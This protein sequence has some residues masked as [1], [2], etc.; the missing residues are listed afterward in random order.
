MKTIYGRDHEKAV[1]D[2]HAEWLC[3]AVDDEGVKTLVLHGPPGIGKTALLSEL[4]ARVVSHAGQTPH[5]H[6]LPYDSSL[7]DLGKTEFLSAALNP[8]WK[9]GNK[10]ANFFWFGA[11]FD[12]PSYRQYRPFSFYDSLASLKGAWLERLDKSQEAAKSTSLTILK[13]ALRLIPAFTV[14][15]SLKTATE[16]GLDLVENGLDGADIL[17]SVRKRERHKIEQVEGAILS[18]SLELPLVLVLD[19]AHWAFAP[20]AGHDGL[21]IESLLNKIL[22]KDMTFIERAIRVL[23]A[24]MKRLLDRSALRRKRVLLVMTV[25]SAAY[26]QTLLAGA[27]PASKGPE[28]P[29]TLGAVLDELGR[30]ITPLAL[31]RLGE[32]D[33]RRVFE[34]AYR[35][36]LQDPS[37]RRPDPVD[38]LHTAAVVRAA[39]LDSGGLPLRIRE[40]AVLH[41]AGIA[42]DGPLESAVIHTKRLRAI[43]D[44]ERGLTDILRFAAILAASSNRVARPVLSNLLQEIRGASAEEVAAQIERVRTIGLFDWAG[45]SDAEVLEFLAPESPGFIRGLDGQATSAL[46]LQI[47]D[48]LVRKAS[49]SVQEWT[50]CAE[51]PRLLWSE[52]FDLPFLAATEERTLSQLVASELKGRFA[53]G[54]VSEIE[55]STSAAWAVWALCIAEWSSHH[56]AEG[57]AELAATVWNAHVAAICDV[58]AS[59]QSQRMKVDAPAPLSRAN[60]CLD[61]WQCGAWIRALRIANHLLDT[62]EGIPGYG[63][64]GELSIN[65]AKVFQ[66]ISMVR[67][68][69]DRVRESAANQPWAR[70][71]EIG[72]E[73]SH[74]W[75]FTLDAVNH[76]FHRTGRCRYLLEEVLTPRGSF[77]GFGDDALHW[78]RMACEE[79]QHLR[80][81]AQR[82][83]EAALQEIA[84]FADTLGVFQ[85]DPAAV[86]G[87]LDQYRELL[88]TPTRQES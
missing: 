22:S 57:H 78:F 72:L 25:D 38:E 33:S 16:I 4:Y 39:I 62:R 49:R 40:L 44:A 14:M 23:D 31:H 63:R 24:D 21:L 80:P 70:R 11:R 1:L 45:P 5:P 68:L 65:E 37:S 60:G 43:L 32:E 76:E 51:M 47:V 42:I 85:L 83:V 48:V 53:P 69:A 18:A 54:Q 56:L 67:T 71:V 86:R 9:P 73:F 6:G 26:A 20:E 41:A 52:A 66:R 64:S 27:S 8:E 19:N 77:T 12:D 2:Q 34:E 82:F 3:A 30:T 50:W 81:D 17:K 29:P 35:S 84:R 13:C 59:V 61:N 87:K 88:V 55:K 28:G 75:L 10:G 36:T 7:L 74:H 46:R 15:E 79:R 58:L